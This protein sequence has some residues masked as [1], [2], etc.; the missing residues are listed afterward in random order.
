[1]TVPNRAGPVHE[2]VPDDEVLVAQAIAGNERAFSAL[3]RRHARYVAGIVY[4][5]LGSDADLEDIVQEGFVD[6]SR[7]LSSLN[8]PKDFRP[9][10]AR[11]VVRRVHKRIARQRR[12]RWLAG[13]VAQVAPTSSDPRG[14]EKVDALYE[15]LSS[16]SADLH[17]P[18]ALHHVEGQTLPEVAAACG[19][20]LATVKRRIAEAAAIVDRRLHESG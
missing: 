4:R 2:I 19:V 10:L 20:S 16:M 13:S 18:W 17:V 3:Y 12:W 11:I 7:A 1:M 14:R 8:E 15:I 5:I 9:W 6:A